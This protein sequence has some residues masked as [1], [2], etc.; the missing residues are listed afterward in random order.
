MVIQDFKK[1]VCTLLDVEGGLLSGS[2]IQK[3]AEKE[4]CR[5]IKVCMDPPPFKEKA[6][7]HVAPGGGAGLQRRFGGP[8]SSHLVGQQRFC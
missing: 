6:K 7:S 5:V 2:F 4:A 8:G 1:S 3:W